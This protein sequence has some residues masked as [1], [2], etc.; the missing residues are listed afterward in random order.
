MAISESTALARARAARA[1]FP[2]GKITTAQARAM[3]VSIMDSLVGYASGNPNWSM[4]GKGNT[5]RTPWGG[6][7]VYWCVLTGSFAADYTFGQAAA[8]AGF[9]MQ[10]PG[11]NYPPVGGTWTV[12][13]YNWGRA[14]GRIV[15]FN[16]VQSGDIVLTNWGRTGAVVDHYDV[17]TGPRSLNVIPVIG[18]NTSTSSASAGAGVYRALRPRNRVVA[19]VRPDWAALARV[20]N[21]SAPIQESDELS[22]AEVK[23]IK[24]YIDQK[25]QVEVSKGTA[26]NLHTGRT[27]AQ[28][29][30]WFLNLIGNRVGRMDRRIAALEATANTHTQQLNTVGRVAAEARELARS[31]PERVIAAR[32]PFKE[33]TSLY[34]LFGKDF[35][36]GALVGYSAASQVD[37]DTHTEEI[38]EA[39]DS[40]ALAI[41][42]VASTEV[43]QEHTEA[44]QVADEDEEK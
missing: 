20:Y 42:E 21:A 29:L 16:S 37:R 5:W 36:F 14:N 2:K 39:L 17:A 38:V 11:N 30:G 33:G 10:Y 19:V 31:V 9:G 25:F 27:G 35:R 4:F 43:T 7:Q 44:V 8:R 34:R 28:P 18:G 40:R 32:V 12:W 41:P 26:D 23:E 22:A 24:D 3:F 1:R 13:V 15:P 6:R